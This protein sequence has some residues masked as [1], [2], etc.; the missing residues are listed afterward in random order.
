MVKYN[1]VSH[2]FP[3]VEAE[4]VEVNTAIIQEPAFFDNPIEN[5]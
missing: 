3:Q 4:L 2:I 1:V 5:A